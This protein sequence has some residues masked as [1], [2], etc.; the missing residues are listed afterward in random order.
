MWKLS[1]DGLTEYLLAEPHT[2]RAEGDER[3]PRFFDARGVVDF[4]L[5]LPQR[6]L[7]DEALREYAWEQLRHEGSA[8][9]TD[10]AIL[11]LVARALVEGRL[12][13][14]ARPVAVG[15][16]VRPQ[17]QDEAERPIAQ[18]A[19]VDPKVHWIEIVLLEHDHRPAAGERYRIETPDGSVREGKLGEEG[20]AL[21]DHMV[22]GTC[23]VT[24][25]DLPRRASEKGR[26]RG[27]RGGGAT[28]APGLPANAQRYQAGASVSAA[29]SC[30]HV[31]VR[32]L[33][34]RCR[35]STHQCYRH[36]E[37]HLIVELSQ[38][39]DGPLDLLVYER[40]PSAWPLWRLEAVASGGLARVPW[41]VLDPGPVSEVANASALPEALAAGGS[42]AAGPVEQLHFE[43]RYGEVSARSGAK[44]EELL[45]IKH[46]L[47]VTLLDDDHEGLEGLTASV[48]LP[49]GEIRELPVAP[50]GKLLIE[51]VPDGPCTVQLHAADLAA[52]VVHTVPHPTQ[53]EHVRAARLWAE[54]LPIPD[55][56]L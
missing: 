5:G 53:M 34:I 10:A 17:K 55:E 21:E 36:D 37:V 44:P 51:Y 46:A 23:R 18:E 11:T 16:G 22:A 6:A 4:L 39:L 41:K 3:L 32:S 14:I 42:L 28:S 1:R 33:E 48:T 20:S 47:S 38:P 9:S 15:G 30:V 35:W 2:A 43:A 49:D 50:G 19:P 52:T 24:F 25:P 13:V 12:T 8:I 45:T 7:L 29:T 40:G 56:K 54:A 31:F 26:A 27:G